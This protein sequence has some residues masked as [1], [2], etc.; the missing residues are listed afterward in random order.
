MYAQQQSHRSAVAVLPQLSTRVEPAAGR[1]CPCPPTAPCFPGSFGS[2]CWGSEAPVGVPGDLEAVGGGWCSG[3]CVAVQLPTA[4]NCPLQPHED[5]PCPPHL[6]TC[7][8]LLQL[9]PVR[10]V[11]RTAQR[12][13]AGPLTKREQVGRHPSSSNAMHMDISTRGNTQSS[14]W[15]ASTLLM[16]GA[17]RPLLDTRAKER[18]KE[19]TP[20]F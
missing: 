3:G 8:S 20:R 16:G 13:S 9:W 14:S 10:G 2:R 11:L 6:P 18:K 5:R 12:T 4:L 1:C 7:V 19:T 17:C 15:A